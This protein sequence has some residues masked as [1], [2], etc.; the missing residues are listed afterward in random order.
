MQKTFRIGPNS[1]AQKTTTKKNGCR[2]HNFIQANWT[3]GIF[4]IFFN[5]NKTKLHDRFRS[6]FLTQ[7]MSTKNDKPHT[8]FRPWFQ[9]ILFCYILF[10]LFICSFSHSVNPCSQYRNADIL[11]WVILLPSTSIS[12]SNPPSTTIFPPPYSIITAITLEEFS[13]APALAAK[14]T[15]RQRWIRN[16]WVSRHFGRARVPAKRTPPTPSTKISA[17]KRPASK[18]EI[19]V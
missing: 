3:Q 19:F 4:F 6:T 7:T 13:T 11:D 18:H 9:L 15:W 8:Y 2:W 17:Q 10:I 12:T 1:S 16:W 14:R 5:N